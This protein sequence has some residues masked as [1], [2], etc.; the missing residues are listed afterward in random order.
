M[1]CKRCIVILTAILLFNC[2]KDN[3]QDKRTKLF[4]ILDSELTGIDFK[5]GIENTLK[6]NILNYLYFYNG[7]GVA[8]SDFNNDGLIDLYFPANQT[9]DKLYLNQGS[10]TFKELTLLS[11]ID[12]SSGWTT[13]VTTV[14]INNDGLQDIYISKAASI[15]ESSGDHNLLYINKGIQ[16]GSQHLGKQPPNTA[17]IFLD[18]PHRRCFLITTGMMTWICF[19]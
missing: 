11:G 8:A 2:S 12:N 7:S 13:G 16:M 4:S 3:L 15:F 18:I 6:L 9:A 19:S 14:D 5:N 1:I 10:F 17:S